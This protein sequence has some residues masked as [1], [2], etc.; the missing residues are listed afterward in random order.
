M[1][2]G[3]PLQDTGPGMAEL[4]H[5][6]AVEQEKERALERGGH[7]LNYGWLLPGRKTFKADC[8]C[9]WSSEGDRA[10][11]LAAVRKHEDENL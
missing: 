11:V 8:T 3:F 1:P 7:R 4:F 2:R 6:L 10:T 9:G 5:D